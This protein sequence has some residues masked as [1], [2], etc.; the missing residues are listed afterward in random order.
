M[1]GNLSA[2]GLLERQPSTRTGTLQ[3]PRR[4]VSTISPY[5]PAGPLPTVSDRNPSSALIHFRHRRCA[6]RPN[7]QTS[8]SSSP[9]N[10][11]NRLNRWRVPVKI[12]SVPSSPCARSPPQPPDLE[13]PSSSCRRA[14]LLRYVRTGSHRS[15]A[16]RF[17]PHSTQLASS[18]LSDLCV[19]LVNPISSPFLVKSS[20]PPPTRG[21]PR[22]P[23]G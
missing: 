9:I 22:P 2:P 16:L 3:M 5:V 8:T 4:A 18:L 14:F 19:P 23:S 10:K 12:K 7:T 20:P 6:R 15:S 13:S 1:S 17:S 21:T 11:R